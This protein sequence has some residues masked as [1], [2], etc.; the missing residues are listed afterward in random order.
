MQLLKDQMI[1]SFV[2]TKSFY[3]ELRRTVK[4]QVDQKRYSHILAVENKAVEICALFAPDKTEMIRAAA[5]LH[6]LTKCYSEEEQRNVCKKYGYPLDKSV[7]FPILHSITA[8]LVI[9]NELSVRFPC[10]KDP[11]LLNAVRWHATGHDKMTLTE[12]IIYLADYIE[13]TREYEECVKLRDYYVSGLSDDRRHNCLHL[14]KTMLISLGYTITEL[15]S[16]NRIIDPNTINAW[17]YF[18]TLINEPEKGF[19]L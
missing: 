17:N 15:V 13:D 3:D 5:I 10:L 14:Y 19:I 7:S 11:E 6:D 16:K 4:G 1:T 8:P 18:Q 12:T 9:S 2:Y